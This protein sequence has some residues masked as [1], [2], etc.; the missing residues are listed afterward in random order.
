[1]GLKQVLEALVQALRDRFNRTTV[2]LK[3]DSVDP[4]PGSMVGFNRTTVGLK[5]IMRDTIAS[6]DP[7]LIAPQWD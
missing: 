6:S 2:G 1:M 5:P 7:V 3:L 4:H